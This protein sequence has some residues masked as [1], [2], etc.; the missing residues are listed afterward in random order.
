LELSCITMWEISILMQE[1]SYFSYKWLQL[2]ARLEAESPEVLALVRCVLRRL[3]PQGKTPQSRNVLRLKLRTWSRRP[4]APKLK[5]ENPSEFRG[6]CCPRWIRTTTN[7][8]KNCR[9]AVRR[10]G[11]AA[12]NIN[13]YL[14]SRK[15]PAM[16]F[17]FYDLICASDC[18]LF[19]A[20]SRSGNRNT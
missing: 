5:K 7:S 10:S 3:I 13:S 12:A 14:N 19:N 6:I 17:L 4:Q 18:I 11:N 9:P 15:Y 16:I 1:P 20:E 8:T 2:C